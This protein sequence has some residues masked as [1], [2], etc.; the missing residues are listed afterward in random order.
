M[1]MRMGREESRGDDGFGPEKS[2]IQARQ[3]RGVTAGVTLIDGL[4]W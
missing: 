4:A 2:F 3:Q 1:P